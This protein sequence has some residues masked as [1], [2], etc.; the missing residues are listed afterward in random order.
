[1]GPRGLWHTGRV[2]EL[3]D[4]ATRSRHAV[5][6]AA[7]VGIATGVIVAGFDEVVVRMQGWVGHRNVVV[8][9]LAPTMGLAVAAIALWIGRTG[10]A[11]SDDYIRSFHRFDELP[12]TAAVHPSLSARTA[13]ARLVGAIASLGTSG[14]M[15]LE[16]PSVY[17][18]S[19]IGANVQHRLRRLTRGAEPGLLLAAGA[20]AGVAA[21]FKAPATGAIFAIEVPFQ[22]D[23]AR[24]MLLPALVA[25]G[26]GYLAFAAFHGTSPVLEIG[27][28]PGFT[29]KDL[30][31]AVLLGVVAGIGARVFARFVRWAKHAG[32]LGSPAA[33]VAIAGAALAV[34]SLLG[35]AL[36]GAAL[37]G[38]APRDHGVVLSSGYSLIG[39][40]LDEHRAIWLL[41]VILVLRCG[42]TGAMMA[43]GAVGGVFI[44]LVVAGAL[45]GRVVGEIADPGQRSLFLVVGVAA[46]LGAGY[47]VPL[48]A[49]MFVAETTGRPSFVVPGLLAAVAAEL[50]MA[51]SS[52]S[53]HQVWPEQPHRR[54]NRQG[55][56]SG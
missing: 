16:G 45:V 15:G 54:V 3:R 17:F 1:M 34:L 44:P 35:E 55:E 19:T 23:L 28:A 20:A 31:A 50:M 26:T 11:T 21:I 22:D 32:T 52:V 4:L 5:V 13:L 10:P 8:I 30:A 33:R 48:A 47:R 27:G 37:T 29:A 42:A 9:A 56:P 53:A 38:E 24:R 18:G 46:F 39:W 41:L 36:T 12:A 25:S 2:E 7:A 51:R 6:L 14:A 49:V 43:G 40:A